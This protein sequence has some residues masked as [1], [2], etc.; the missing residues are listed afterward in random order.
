MCL[1]ICVCCVSC[2]VLSIA[3]VVFCVYV[4]VGWCC[5]YL[6][7]VSLCCWGCSLGVVFWFWAAYCM[8]CLSLCVFV[9]LVLGLYLCVVLSIAGVVFCVVCGCVAGFG[10]WAWWCFCFWVLAWFCFFVDCWCFV[11]CLVF[12]VGCWWWFVFVGCLG[13]FSVFWVA[14]CVEIFWSYIICVGCGGALRVSAC[15]AL[16]AGVTACFSGVCF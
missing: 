16:L 3:G 10:V 4:C 14:D 9:V 8:A 6:W 13:G 15:V 1:G 12:L 2:V 7:C 11:F 5:V